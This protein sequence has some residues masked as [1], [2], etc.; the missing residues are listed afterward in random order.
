MKN[1]VRM[2]KKN[3]RHMRM[4]CAQ[5]KMDTKMSLHMRMMGIQIYITYIIGTH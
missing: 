5:V 2:D 4:M 1:E 3:H